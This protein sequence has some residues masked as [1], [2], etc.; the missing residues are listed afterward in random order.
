MRCKSCDYSLW[1]IKDRQCPECG[2][3]FKPSDFEFNLNSVR[4]CCPHCQQDYYGTGERGHLVPSAFNCVRCSRP[5]SMDEMVLLPAEG[6]TENLTEVAKNP[7]LERGKRRGFWSAFFAT[8]GQ[9]LIA[10]GQLL[11]HT[12]VESSSGSALIFALVTQF[13]I[14][15]VS[16]VPMIAFFGIMG[17]VGGM[18]ARGAG[19]GAAAA[20]GAMVG[21]MVAFGG[22]ILVCWLV[23][24]LL[25]VACAHVLL[26]ITGG[27]A[28]G[29]GR[30]YQA[31]SYA[32]GANILSAVP[33][34]GPYI[35]WIWWLISACIALKYAQ[36]VH[37]G[38]ATAAVLA[39]PMLAL[40]GAITL[41]AV[42]FVGVIAGA[43][44]R[45]SAM[46]GGAGAAG[47]M[48]TGRAQTITTAITMAPPPAHVAELIRTGDIDIV[49]LF[50]TSGQNAQPYMTRSMAT[51]LGSI[52]LDRFEFAPVDIQPG[53]VKEAANA[54]PP[55]VVA[56]RLG[57]I[58]FTYCG[59]DPTVIPAGDPAGQLWM[60]IAVSAPK[61]AMP[62]SYAVGLADGMVTQVMASSFAAELVRQNA[63]R[64]SVGLQPL[65]DPRAVTEQQPVKGL[66]PGMFKIPQG[67]TP[68]P[69]RRR[70]AAPLPP[71]PSRATPTDVIDVPNDQTDPNPEP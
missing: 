6:V 5:V 66:A 51:P 10:P 57:D 42:I 62:T 69:P 26:K 37:G 18:G 20:T 12:P 31:L 16:V 30:T 24:H 71:P 9:S 2:I 45:M 36:K 61:E 55:N 34:F 1:Q 44:A 21:A 46:G 53:Y 14:T 56:Y 29:I 54:L 41:Y 7:W 27:C 67:G 17:L 58:V 47:I 19:P 4:F 13:L 68:A 8:I 60:A 52:T 39:L 49:D 48:A 40:A 28:H 59:I 33:C 35:G 11:R 63:L 25:T 32:S 64:A 50:D 70:S 3:P 22:F 15:I 65:P 23:M 38:R 43:N